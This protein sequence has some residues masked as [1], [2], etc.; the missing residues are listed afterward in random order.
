MESFVICTI[1][2]DVISCNDVVRW[3]FCGEDDDPVVIGNICPKC[4]LEEVKKEKDNGA[5]V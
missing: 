5:Q 3:T 1:C 2:K 4:H